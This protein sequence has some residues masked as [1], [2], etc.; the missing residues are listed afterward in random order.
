MELDRLGLGRGIHID[1]EVDAFCC[2]LGDAFSSEVRAS[3]ASA[4][5]AD[6]LLGVVEGRVRIGLLEDVYSGVEGVFTDVEGVWTSLPFPIEG[7]STIFSS[8]GSVERESSEGLPTADVDP[9]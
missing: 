8:I 1:D 2:L 9:E 3:V 5:A 6:T 4:W 7:D